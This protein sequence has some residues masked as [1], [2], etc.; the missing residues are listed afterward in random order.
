MTQRNATI[1]AVVAGAVLAGTAI[2]IFYPPFSSKGP[3]RPK[4]DTPETAAKQNDSEGS[5]P[6]AVNNEASSE[7]LVAPMLELRDLIAGYERELVEE[8]DRTS[9]MAQAIAEWTAAKSAGKT[10]WGSERWMKPPQYY[11]DLETPKL[12]EECFAGSLFY[13]EMSIFD[14]PRAGLESL[15][16]FHNGFGEL[17]RREDMWKGILHAYD[18]L[19]RR[20][21]PNQDLAEVVMASGQLDEMRKLYRFPPLK[22]QV[23]GREEQ[24]LAAQVK[25]LKRYR[26]YLDDYSPE[27][28][29]GTPG[30]F[31]EPC[32]IAQVAL[33]LA[34]QIDPEQ[35]ARI[36]PPISGVRWTQE[37]DPEDLKRFL[38]LVL[39]G[40][41]RIRTKG[42]AMAP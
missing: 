19:G 30:I 29:G 14:E 11:R 32:S 10:R 1:V 21:D 13:N 16:I 36:E 27:K 22:D 40:L 8:G 12:A 41:A 28:T 18:Q 7:P 4:P 42:A 3:G 15:R 9:G 5:K 2:V 6:R 26:Q 20:I 34:K 25:L 17:L 24:F 37:Q 39:D 31:R 38:S 23:R 35:F 33:M